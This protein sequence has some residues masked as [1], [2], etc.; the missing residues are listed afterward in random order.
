MRKE[1]E[2]ARKHQAR[3]KK[4]IVN[5]FAPG[6]NC[7]VF[8]GNMSGCIFAMPG[9][10]VTQQVTNPATRDEKEKELPAADLATLRECAA[11]VREYFWSESAMTVIFCVCRDCFSYPDNMSQF[12]RE[13]ECREGLLSNTF[14]N[15]RYMRLHINKWKENGAKSRVLT[16]VDVYRAT[17]EKHLDCSRKAMSE[18]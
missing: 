9:A 1:K 5:N 7:Q 13:F 3:E 11:Q 6:A 2:K 15:N 12:E 16:L 8:N 4:S 10:N 14:R 17:V 18:K